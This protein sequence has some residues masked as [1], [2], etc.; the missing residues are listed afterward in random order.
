MSS[1]FREG[2]QEATLADHE[3]RIVENEGD[4]GE[5]KSTLTEVLVEVR[6][7]RSSISTSAKLISGAIAVAGAVAAIVGTVS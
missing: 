6:G 7:I 1:D 2:K 5:I 4:I 3:R